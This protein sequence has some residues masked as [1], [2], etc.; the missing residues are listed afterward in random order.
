MQ[1]SNR[2]RQS[3]SNRTPMSKC[4]SHQGWGCRLLF[5]VLLLSCTSSCESSHEPFPP[6]Q[7]D[8][9]DAS[10]VR[11]KTHDDCEG[12]EICHTDGVCGVPWG[13]R[14]FIVECSFEAHDKDLQGKYRVN[15]TGQHEHKSGVLISFEPESWNKC[16]FLDLAMI[17]DLHDPAR[18]RCHFRSETSEVTLDPDEV[19]RGEFCLEDGCP[20][21]SVEYFMS[22]RSVEMRNDRGDL[23]RF[24]LSP[25]PSQEHQNRR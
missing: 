13:T 8:K 6:L 2:I 5:L 18:F 22:T 25:R 20:G 10:L 14:F 17:A 12:G 7:S 3:A 19:H 21:L 15:C 4:L 24:R 23:L 11:C 9:N 1:A 16:A